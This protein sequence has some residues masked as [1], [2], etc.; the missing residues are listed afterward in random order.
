MTKKK[1]RQTRQRTNEFFE[2]AGAR[3][4]K[5]PTSTKKTKFNARNT[6]WNATCAGIHH[7]RRGRNSIRRNTNTPS[8]YHRTAKH[9]HTHTLTFAIHLFA[10]FLYIFSVVRLYEVIS[11]SNSKRKRQ[12]KRRNFTFITFIVRFRENEDKTRSKWNNECTTIKFI[13]NECASETQKL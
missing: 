5:K 13:F 1:H 4:K 2:R 9:T 8:S 7:H 12:K 6:H 10:L 3:R 11:I